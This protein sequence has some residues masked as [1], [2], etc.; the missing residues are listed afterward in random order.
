MPR[1][2]LISI[3]GLLVAGLIFAAPAMAQDEG[4]NGDTIGVVQSDEEPE[5][6]DQRITL[7]ESASEQGKESSSEGL[8]TANEAREK[9][10]EFGRERAEEARQKGKDK[11]QEARERARERAREA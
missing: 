3:L 9:G 5:E 10:S 8:E 11:A 1:S 2:V 7:P 4:D 6:V